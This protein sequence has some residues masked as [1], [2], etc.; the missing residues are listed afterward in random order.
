MNTCIRPYLFLLTM[1]TFLM[2]AVRCPAPVFAKF[3]GID[4]ESQVAGH[5]GEIEIL[6]W[7]WGESNSGPGVSNPTGESYTNNPPVP[8]RLK[9]RDLIVVKE[10]DKSTPKLFLKSCEGQAVAEGELQ[11]TDPTTGQVYLRIKMKPVYITSYQTGGS[12]G[13]VVPVD[14]I[15]LNFGQI[16][17]EYAEGMGSGPKTVEGWDF[18]RDQ[19][20][21]PPGT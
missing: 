7:S 10:V 1:F 17:F 4:G 13:D 9:V 5:E 20:T 18:D 2:V 15:S 12:S 19:P 14:T 8:D 16:E 6:S 3:D 11:I 21:P